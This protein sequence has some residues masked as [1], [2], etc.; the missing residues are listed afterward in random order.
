[1]TSSDRSQTN[2]VFDLDKIE[3]KVWM[4]FYEDGIF[5]LFLG[6]LL[7]IMGSA[8]LLPEGALD[9]SR[10]PFI[11]TMIGFQVLALIAFFLAKRFITYPRIGR[12]KFGPKGKQRKRKAAV[13]LTGSALMGLVIFLLS[14]SLATGRLTLPHPDIFFPSIWAANMLIVFGLLA[15]FTGNGRFYLAGFMYAI[16]LPAIV[17]FKRLAG[18]DIAYFAFF[19]P[20]IPLLV[21]G[22]IVMTRFVR[23]YPSLTG[24][25][26]DD[27]I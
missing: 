14:A 2:S 22:S 4:R 8:R 21:V 7:L 12:V 9:E 25:L 20:A 27:E 3:Y 10:T 1:M 13:V 6:V 17:A 18:F 15:H 11:A 24:N 19:L 5:E 26:V 23:T 16:P